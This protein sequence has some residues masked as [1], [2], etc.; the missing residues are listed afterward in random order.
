MVRLGSRPIAGSLMVG[1]TKRRLE[2]AGGAGGAE[3]FW[4]EKTMKNMEN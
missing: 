2:I 4:K 3:R 1:T